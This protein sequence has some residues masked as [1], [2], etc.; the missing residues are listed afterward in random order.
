MRALR[1][2]LLIACLP[3]IASAQDDRDECVLHW[4]NETTEDELKDFF[5]CAD[6]LYDRCDRRV[7]IRRE[8]HGSDHV[9]LI[10]SMPEDCGTMPH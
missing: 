9:D 8:D 6:D 10:V 2:G 4:T 7:K 5:R 3:I 1:T